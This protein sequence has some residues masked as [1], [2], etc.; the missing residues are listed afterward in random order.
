MKRKLIFA[1]CVI[2]VLTMGVTFADA[3]V[4]VKPIS[5]A[6]VKTVDVKKAVMSIKV[7]NYKSTDTKLTG[8]FAYYNGKKKYIYK[9]N[10]KETM[11]ISLPL[12]YKGKKRIAI[13]PYYRQDKNSRVYVGKKT[14]EFTIS[15]K[16]LE[17]ASVKCTKI[18]TNKVKVLINRAP[19]SDGTRIQY[20]K[21]GKWKNA[22]DVEG[23]K[24]A[25]TVIL[26][27]ASKYKY[28]VRAYIADK[29]FTE[30]VYYTKAS[31]A[32]KPEVNRFIWSY[33]S[34]L[35]KYKKSRV[36]FKPCKVYYKDG[37]AMLRC[38]FINRYSKNLKTI[39]V[40]AKVSS[41]GK[42][43]GKQ[44]FTSGNIKANSVKYRVVKLKTINKGLDL[45]HGG[46]GWEYELVYAI[47]SNGNK[48]FK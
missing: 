33:P 44:T 26:K 22:M 20:L 40:N 32:A 47:D 14:K 10:K 30:K 45:P 46:T 42:P 25:A 15:S 9:Y 11:L 19:K 43:V 1:I 16:Q 27:K 8:F 12:P 24:I 18:A 21:D 35:S 31:K 41:E 7:K 37:A 6:S 39:K 38:K 17:K 23:N 34:E 36:Y 48:I 2:L 28:R 5:S 29:G 13:A 4:N 3:A